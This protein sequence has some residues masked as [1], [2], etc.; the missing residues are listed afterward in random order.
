MVK[1]EDEGIGVAPE[2]QV[3]IFNRFERAVSANEISG[4]GLG[5]YISQQIVAAHGGEIRL[6]S[7]VGKGSCFE[8]RFPLQAHKVLRFRRAG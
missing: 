5:L 3:K 2:A 6:H 8:V 7:E 1:V 4:L